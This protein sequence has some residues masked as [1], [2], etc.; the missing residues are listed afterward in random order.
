MND[1]YF[2]VLKVVGNV[3]KNRDTHN[4]KTELNLFYLIIEI[5]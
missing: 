4:K 1:T 5:I 3:A 2:Q